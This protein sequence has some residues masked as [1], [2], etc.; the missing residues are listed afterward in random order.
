LSVLQISRED[1]TQQNFAVRWSRC[2]FRQRATRH[3]GAAGETDLR[4]AHGPSNIYLSLAGLCRKAGSKPEADLYDAE[5]LA[6]W[7][8]WDAKLPH[9]FFIQ[10]Q[11]SK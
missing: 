8:G 6:I 3:T 1:Q 2:W 4:Q 11:L 5:R 7:R 9:N 10:G